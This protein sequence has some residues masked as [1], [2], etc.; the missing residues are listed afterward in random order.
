[1]TGY[2]HRLLARSARNRAEVHPL[3]RLPQAGLF[4]ANSAEPEL[5]GGYGE[6][7]SSPANRLDG[8]RQPQTIKQNVRHESMA[9]P[10][11]AVEASERASA[12]A[13]VA[14]ITQDD[15]ASP[16]ATASPHMNVQDEVVKPRRTV[17]SASAMPETELA[18]ALAFVSSDRAPALRRE[19]ITAA[20]ATFRL[21]PNQTPQD[22]DVSRIVVSASQPLDVTQAQFQALQLASPLRSRLHQDQTEVHVSIG[23]IEVTALP[24]PVPAKR[25]DAPRSKAMTL[26][27]YL[28][29]RQQAR[30]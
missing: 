19:Q 22:A 3:A 30:T 2:F 7:A 1:M 9:A 5:Q 25:A 23:R 6:V 27:E 24:A 28:R 20:Q 13:K 16:H 29:Q 15:V 21:M 10:Q 18:T 4:Q 26:D 14:A 11:P 8:V 12:T 17:Q